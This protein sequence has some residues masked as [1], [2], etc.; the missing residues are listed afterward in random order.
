MINLRRVVC[1][2]VR[3]FGCLGEAENSQ[4]VNRETRKLQNRVEIATQSDYCGTRHAACG[5]H[6]ARVDGVGIVSPPPS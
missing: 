2:C 3:M 5:M 1:M 6:D 4:S